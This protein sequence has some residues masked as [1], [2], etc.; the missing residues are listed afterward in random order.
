MFK[1]F[2]DSLTSPKLVSKYY[3]DSFWRTLFYY[4]LLVVLIM[5]PTVVNLI[6]SDFLSASTKKEIRKC[7]I[8][9]EVPF[10]I[11]DG[12]LSNID[13]NSD[14]IYINN[15]FG[16]FSFVF[17]ENEQDYSP[18]IDRI[19][20]VFGKE[21]VYL[22]LSVS[23][24]KLFKYQNYEYLNNID[25]SDPSLFSDVD[26]WDHMFYLTELFIEDAKPT[27]VTLYSIYYVM[28]WFVWL[29]IFCLIISF[30][31]KF[32]TMN[33]VSFGKIFKLSIYS[34]TPFVVC[35]VLSSLFGIG[36][37]MYIGYGLSAIYNMKTINQLIKDLYEVRKEGE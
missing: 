27:F 10:V 29:L 25:F 2:S 15:S 37:L 6:T 33:L 14:E 35:M 11:E 31:S 32:R 36:L 26:F 22:N 7:F 28:Y 21:G 34:L 3:R 5:V 23:N 16:S 13:E 17:T 30:L 20:I 19:A 9:E 12:I 24:I 8:G 4:L 18:D 1:R